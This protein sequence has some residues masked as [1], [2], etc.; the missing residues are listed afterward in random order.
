M[1]PV[2][3][4]DETTAAHN[5]VALLDAA[6]DRGAAPAGDPERDPAA[7]RGGRF[8]WSVPMAGESTIRILMPGVDLKQIR[9]MSADAP[10]LFPNAG[11]ESPSQ[12]DAWWWNDAVGV[13]ASSA[14]WSTDPGE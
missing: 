4:A 10:C 9:A 6:R 14:R 13:L 1:Q 2:D 3:N 5:L 7:D 8:A 11:G 12:R